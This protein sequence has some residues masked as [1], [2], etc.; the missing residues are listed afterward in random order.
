MFS[1]PIRK[2]Q[3]RLSERKRWQVERSVNEGKAVVA[4]NLDGYE[5]SD[6]LLVSAKTSGHERIL[7][8]GCTFHMSMNV[9]C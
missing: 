1:I 4:S 6:V 5:S 7:D 8:L 9:E 2:S 3:K